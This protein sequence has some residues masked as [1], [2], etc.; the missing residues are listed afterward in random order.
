M[1]LKATKISTDVSDNY[2]FC[3]GKYVTSA[4][5]DADYIA[6]EI[7]KKAYVYEVF[8]DIKTAYTAASTGTLTVGYKEPG[9]AIVAAWVPDTLTLSEVTGVKPTEVSRYFEN[10]GIITL[11]VVKGTSVADAVARLFVV[12]SVIH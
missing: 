4:D 6:F 5:G 1:A 10:G 2:R 3:K 8:I 9:Q 12:Y 7:P 11:G